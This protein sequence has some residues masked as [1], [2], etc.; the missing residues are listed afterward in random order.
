MNCFRDFG[1]FRCKDKD[2]FWNL[3]GKRL[4]FWFTKERRGRDGCAFILDYCLK[5]TNQ[6]TGL[7]II[8]MLNLFLRDAGDST[9]EARD[10]VDELPYTKERHHQAEVKYFVTKNKGLVPVST[11]HQIK[12]PFLSW[13]R[14]A[15]NNEIIGPAYLSHHG[16]SFS[17]ASQYLNY[18]AEA[19]LHISLAR[20]YSFSFLARWCCSASKKD[21]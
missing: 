6:T 9:Q 5:H 20:R 12:H 4:I 8:A 2:Y 21:G 19:L 13:F 17:P 11:Q 1:G 18:T 7:T 10:M 16:E 3:Q 15:Q 14:T